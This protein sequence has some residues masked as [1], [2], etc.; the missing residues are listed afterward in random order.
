MQMLDSASRLQQSAPDQLISL[1]SA[2]LN[3]SRDIGFNTGVGRALGLIAT[4]YRNIG[5]YQ[6][7]IVLFKQSIPFF[8]H[9]EI[10]NEY[11]LAAVHSAMFGCY[12]SQG[13]YDSAAMNAYKVIDI[14]SHAGERR[15]DPH[16]KAVRPLIDA[17]QYLGICWMQLGYYDRAKQ[18]IEKA[19][20]LSRQDKAHYQL[21]GILVNKGG[22]YMDK[23]QV[24]AALAI[25]KEGLSLEGSR[26]DEVYKSSLYVGVA[27]AYLEKKMPDEAYPIL[28]KVLEDKEGLSVV[29]DSK[30]TAAY[31]LGKI[32]YDRKDYSKALEVLLPAMERARQKKIRYTAIGP[33]LTL[34]KVYKAQG[35]LGQAYEE[36]VT[37]HQLS[38]SMLSNNKIQ[39]LSL[40]DIAL[41]TSE[42]DKAIVQG[43]LL[44]ANQRNKI[45]QKDF[46]L[47]TISIT[48]FLL[49][50]LFIAIYRS[51]M[52]KRRLQEE[53]IRTLSKDREIIQLKAMMNGEEKER[54]RFAREL[55]DGFISQL[56]A[57]KMNFA[58]ISDHLP[59]GTRFDSNMEQFEEVIGELRKT[60]HNLMPEIL[61]RVGL[62]E[63]VQT[64][65]ER[66]SLAHQIDIYFEIYGFIPRLQQEFELSIYRMIQEAIQNVVK[67]AHATEAIVQINCTDSALS[68]T[69]EDNGQ[70]IAPA[71]KERGSGTGLASLDTRIKSLGGVLHINS[72]EGVGTTINFEFDSIDEIKL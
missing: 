30:I 72:E 42:K 55:H 33:Y 56:S 54:T 27:A 63:A 43:Q 47:I 2:A 48:S 17:Y 34:A 4:A 19:E 8:L 53:K 11:Y 1:A 70:G 7:S 66:M 15:I 52:H 69:I 64:F 29:D 35:R 16:D 25:Y 10:D 21:P 68:V 71:D 57:V 44:I 22:V 39:A 3:D 58:A 20:Q 67:H 40:L 9:G 51:N 61:L 24:D 32:Y 31:L 6:K 13:M 18:Y 12:F 62:A 65:C 46:L 28:M 45:N 38:D 50:I 23:G 49:I 5:A 36:M 14:Y 60:A 41:Q 59:E 26:N 37:M